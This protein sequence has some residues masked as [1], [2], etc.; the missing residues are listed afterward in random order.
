MIKRICYVLLCYV[1]DT[2]NPLAGWF[3]VSRFRPRRGCHVYGEV[4]CHT[5]AIFVEDTPRYGHVVKTD[6]MIPQTFTV[7]V[8]CFYFLV[9]LFYN[10]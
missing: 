2:V 5:V 4:G 8:G 6:Y 1:Q 9:F 7:T 3:G 10:F